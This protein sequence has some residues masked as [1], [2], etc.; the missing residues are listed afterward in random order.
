MFSTLLP[1]HFT[2]QSHRG[3]RGLLPENTIPAF[4]QSLACKVYILEFDLVVTGD[5]QLLVSHEAWFSALLSTHFYGFAIEPHEEQQHNIYRM[6]YN[7][8]KRYDC[9]K[10]RH[11]QF[12]HQK[13][14]AATK[15]LWTDMVAA[16]EQYAAQ[17]DLPPI[18]Y[19]AELKTEGEAADGLFQPA[20]REFA[21]L[22][23]DTACAL[24]IDQRCLM[25]SFDIRLV[26]AMREVAPDMPL[27]LLVDN[28][29]GFEKNIYR[30]GFVPDF[31]APH[32][33]LITPELVYKTHANG[34]KLMAW[35]VNN[36]SAIEQLRNMGVDS[37]I[38][39]YPNLNLLL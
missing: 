4:I 25:Q 13:T 12:I 34:M 36:L 39:D 31:Y 3:A 11:P 15:P 9:G 14:M 1:D 7:Q 23:Y 16:V 33:A 8:I 24:Q 35:T 6:T 19:N 37:V 30:L 22:A 17:T 32:Y 10:R 5:G 26:R 21:Q 20:P 28:D 27:S 38:T 2:L 29:D 18:I